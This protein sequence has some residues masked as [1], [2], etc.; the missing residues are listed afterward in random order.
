MNVASLRKAA[1]AFAALALCLAAGAASADAQSA[2]PN[3][4]VIMTDDQ[5]VNDLIA[6]PATRRAFVR[7][8]VS[9]ANS[10]VSYPVCCPSR[11]S[12][13]TGRYAHNHGVM[14]LYLPTGGYGRFNDQDALPVWLQRAGYRTA[15][16]GK[17]MNGYGSDRPAIVPPG[18]TDWYGAVDPTTYRMWNYTLNENGRQVMYGGP[19]EEDPANYQTDVLRN[20]ALD[21]IRRDGRSGQPFFLS[22]AFLAPHYEEGA[23]RVRTGV[24]VRAAPRHRGRFA[25]LPLP[26]PPGFNE[27]DR[28]DKPGFMRRFKA[29]DGTAIGR[30]T[31][32]F[33]ARRESLLAVDEAVA[34]IVRE[35]TAQG[36]LSNTYLL[37]TSDNGYLQGEH[38][39]P[40]GKMLPY[41][42]STQV[43]LMLRGPG[44]RGRRLS[45]EPVSNI[46]LAPTILEIAGAN[47]VGGAPI[48]GR[49]LL[50]FA[51]RP[52]LRSE[53]LVLHETGGLR[54]TSLQPEES[55]DGPIPVRP[56]RTYRAV[57]N[58]R[59]LYVVYRSGERELYDLELDP[60][61]IR[62]RHRDPRYAATRRALQIELDRLA[63]CRGRAC[64]LPGEPIPDPLDRETH[65]PTGVPGGAAPLPARRR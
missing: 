24:T 60:A 13:L 51:K 55:D 53:R 42:P 31:A 27:R 3:V 18:W 7:H 23:V 58:D 8:G 22:V 54:A 2:R 17:Y 28:S 43:P 48:D 38:A 33:R 44:I 39:V 41:D 4:V 29:L 46:D 63:T 30:I 56:V 12:Y 47:A 10:T 19:G 6:M 49:S 1:A 50:K 45:R 25:T 37:F 9:F 34:A 62:S 16:I 11:A 21:V 20:K 59:W 65:T 15:H 14:G 35:L 26:R 32:E 57:R 36:A 52:K 61:Q 5:T 40:S 64:R